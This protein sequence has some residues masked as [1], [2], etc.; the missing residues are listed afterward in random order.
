MAREER[1]T[2]RRHPLVFLFVS[3]RSVSRI[4]SGSSKPDPVQVRA[5]A[6]YCSILRSAISMSGR[7]LYRGFI[8]CRGKLSAC[9]SLVNIGKDV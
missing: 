4:A 1:D 3:I 7:M 9:L 2:N 8:L 6:C 5:A